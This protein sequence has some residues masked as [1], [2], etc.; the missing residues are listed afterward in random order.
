MLYRAKRSNFAIKAHEE[1]NDVLGIIFN[2][3]RG[4][5]FAHLQAVKV[6]DQQGTEGT[7]D[8]W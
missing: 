6:A 1:E 7:G 8:Q 2:T 4:I 3:H 5:S